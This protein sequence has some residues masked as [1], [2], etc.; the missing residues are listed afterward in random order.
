MAK[1]IVN[2]IGLKI[3][4][5]VLALVA[6]YA[7]RE[8]I[9]NEIVV[10]DVPLKIRVPEGWA[11]L[12][13]SVDMLNINLRG[14]QEDIR[15]LDRK[16][17]KAVVDLRSRASDQP[18]EILLSSRNIE[19]IGGLRVLALTPNR[20]AIRLDRELEKKVPVKGKTL[21]KPLSGDVDKVACEPA[22]V[23]LRGPAQHLASVEW[24]FTEPVDVDGRVASFG[25]RSRVQPPATTWTA[26]F[27]PPDVMVNISIAERSEQREWKD[28]PV[29]AIVKPGADLKVEIAPATVTVQVK[30][31]SEL[32]A[33]IAATVPAAFVDCTELESSASYDLPVKIFLASPVEVAITA[34]PP[35]A[36]VVTGKP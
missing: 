24:V 5:L 28:V 9:S 3:M 1:F 6:W 33:R 35:F 13:Q 36:H 2:N 23:L 16:Q 19:G 7:V 21:G 11:I 29:T 12:D 15:L 27:D 4:A 8:T 34:D 26:L 17:I 10:A 30:G 18:G 31:K 32:L 25:K 14:S 22:V 20:V